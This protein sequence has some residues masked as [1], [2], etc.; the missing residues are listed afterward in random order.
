MFKDGKKRNRLYMIYPLHNLFSHFLFEKYKSLKVTYK[1]FK[2][3]DKPIKSLLGMR[4][5][6]FPSK[7]KFCKL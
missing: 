4:R 2:V 5:N 6:K 1:A 3:V 7:R